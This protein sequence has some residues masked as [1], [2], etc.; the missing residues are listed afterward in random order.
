MRTLR[1]FEAQVSAGILQL[2]RHFEGRDWATR[3][4]RPFEGADFYNTSTCVLGCVFS[5]EGGYIAGMKAL[6]L[7]YKRAHAPAFGFAP[8]D[9]AFAEDHR[10]ADHLATEWNL[11][12]NLQPAT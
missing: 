11:R 12:L 2:D 4:S 7:S 10:C 3:I 1:R 5:S 6:G 9:E 8:G